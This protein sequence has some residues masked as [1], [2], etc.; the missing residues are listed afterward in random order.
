MPAIPALPGT[1]CR[2]RLYLMR[3]GA[4][5]YFDDAGLPLDPRTV[6]LTAEGRAQAQAAAELLADVDF[7][8]AFCSGLTRTRETARIVLGARALPLHEEPRLKEVRGGRFDAVPPHARERVIGHAYETAT[9]ADG[10]FIG[11][12][13]WADF[14]ERILA[15]WSGL[16]ARNDWRNLLLVAHDGVNRMLMSHFVGA[17]L[18]GLKGFEQDPACLNLI[19]MDVRDGVAERVYL[20]AV[21]IAAYDPIRDGKHE[22]VMEGIHRAYRAQ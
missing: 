5:V 12:E 8:L 19:E 2:R 10:R 22:T 21:N 3:H 4:V 7:D 16:L 11:G 13:A 9:D 18:A 17:G 15:G 20:R 1:R 14:R 6:P